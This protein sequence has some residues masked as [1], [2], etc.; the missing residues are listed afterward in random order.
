MVAESEQTKFN[1]TILREGINAIGASSDEQL[2]LIKKGLEYLD[3][4]FDPIPLDYLTWLEDNNE[5]S[6]SFSKQVRDLYKKIENSVG[7]LEWKE[8]NTFI[9]KDSSDVER[10]RELAKY[11]IGELDGV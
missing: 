2:L 11:L 9:A 7:H 5:I 1:L 4:V 8:V 10:W 3:N 6:Q